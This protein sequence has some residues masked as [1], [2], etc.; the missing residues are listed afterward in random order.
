MKINEI[1]AS[2]Q[3]EGRFQGTPAIFVR[4]S[5]CPNNC[6][7]CDTDHESWVD[8]SLDDII[9]AITGLNPDAR[10]KH[11][12]LTGGEPMVQN[13]KELETLVSTLVVQGYK[14]QIETSGIN[15]GSDV[16]KKRFGSNVFV[17][18]SP[19]ATA[20]KRNGAYLPQ[21]IDELKFVYPFESKEVEEIY[22]KY[23]SEQDN[24]N[25]PTQIAIQPLTMSLVNNLP[26]ILPGGNDLALDEI[27]NRNREDAFNFCVEH[28]HIFSPRLHI[29]LDFK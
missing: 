27:D 14:V 25:H 24:I 16:L 3:G 19:K 13:A 1:F 5:G 17:T 23:A 7:F 20:L 18:V 12:V 26:E 6:E 10:I 29:L 28:G 11:I 4:T 22:T 15:C 2:V 8:Q 9:I 21:S